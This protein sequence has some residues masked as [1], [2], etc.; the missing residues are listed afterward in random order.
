M[1]EISVSETRKFLELL[2]CCRALSTHGQA[3]CYSHPP[4][5]LG[6]TVVGLHLPAD[7]VDQNRQY[8]GLEGYH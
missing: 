3:R 1:N 4:S 5:H 7:E 6:R 8:E 2:N